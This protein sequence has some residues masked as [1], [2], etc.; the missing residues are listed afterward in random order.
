V[1]KVI[2]LFILLLVLLSGCK[3]EENLVDTS[4][5]NRTSFSMNFLSTSDATYE[6][7][8]KLFVDERDEQFIQNKFELVKQ[9]QTKKSSVSTLSIVRYL[10]GKPLLIQLWHD[11][12]KDE[13]LIYDIIDVPE[14]V[15][16][17]FEDNF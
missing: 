15:A 17:F 3:E 9:T 14:D 8:K 5:P 11:T 13:Y 2:F 16:A 4:S 7:F 12:E 10:D 6:E 1:K